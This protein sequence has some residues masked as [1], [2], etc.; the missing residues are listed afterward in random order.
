MNKIG[1]STRTF[2]GKKNAVMVKIVVIEMIP[3]NIF[4]EIFDL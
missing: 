2:S 3:V 1:A 4:R